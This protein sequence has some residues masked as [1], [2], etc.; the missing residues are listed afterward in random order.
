MAF[1]VNDLGFVD[2]PALSGVVG[3]NG[4][5][6][7]RYDSDDTLTTISG[8]DY[9]PAKTFRNNELIAVT[10]DSVCALYIVTGPV[11]DNPVLH[12]IADVDSFNYQ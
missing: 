12:K 8:A 11:N 9:F 7:W 2:F 6:F 5:T 10:G 3:L 4:F 1:D